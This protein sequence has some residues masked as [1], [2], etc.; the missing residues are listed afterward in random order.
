[1]AYALNFI[2]N[3]LPKN[4][5]AVLNMH[6]YRQGTTVDALIGSMLNAG[7]SGSYKME[8]DA[9]TGK[10]S[11]DA[12]GNSKGTEGS[13]ATS[14]GLAFVLGQGPREVLELNT[15]TS[16]AIR[17]LGIRGTLQTHSNENLPQG[18]TLQEATKT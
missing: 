4:M 1:M 18:S 13:E 17:V 5:E 8:Y 16:Q 14:A 12:N 2:K 11:K 6:A 15:G 3:S 7:S 9:V 10:A